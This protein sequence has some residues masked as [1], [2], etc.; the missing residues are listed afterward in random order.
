MATDMA[1][2]LRKSLDDIGAVSHMI[3]FGRPLSLAYDGVKSD[4]L[5]ECVAYKL[6]C[7]RE[8]NTMKAAQL[9][10]VL[11]ARI[12]LDPCL[13]SDTAVKLEVQAVHSHLRWILFVDHDD[14][15]I[16]TTSQPEPILAEIAAS[17]LMS[18]VNG[19]MKG[20][21]TTTDDD[22]HWGLTMEAMFLQLMSPGFI[23]K[24]RTG[25]LVS[26]ML[27]VM[28]R[29][30]VLSEAPDDHPD[31]HLKFAQSFGVVEFLSRLLRT[32]KLLLDTAAGR[33]RSKSKTIGADFA[34][35][36][37]TFTYWVST[38]TALKPGGLQSLLH[39]LVHAQAAMQLSPKQVTWELLV[40]IYLG[41]SSEPGR[42]CGD[43][44]EVRLV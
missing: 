20:T 36:R 34:D 18:P 19:P 37:M 10:A 28:A 31:T 7:S 1:A 25:E 11:S 39:N 17:L 41:K 9:F 3:T 21:S 22:N 15:C 16:T 33:S 35:A 32:P 6:L 23:D 30:F 4:A 13:Q 44:T 38:K 26:R 42:G 40:P 24:G 43:E 5:R 12:S 14:G 2:E 27:C 29:D 8:Y